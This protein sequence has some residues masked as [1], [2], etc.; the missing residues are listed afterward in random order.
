[1]AGRQAVKLPT[2]PGRSIEIRGSSPPRP[3]MAPPPP[4]GG[5]SGEPP[6]EHAGI[7][8]AAADE[9]RVG[10]GEVAEGARRHAFNHHQPSHTQAPSIPPD[11]GG[12]VW[13][14]LDGDRLER[15]VGEQPFDRDRAGA[16]ADIPEALAA[17]RRQARQHERTNL[18]LGDLPVMLEEIVRKP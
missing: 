15:A 2:G 3:A 1:M 16:G 6:I 10:R 11:A 5:E 12:P 14:R 18:A 7:A 17:A 4:A 13:A 8:G 9:D